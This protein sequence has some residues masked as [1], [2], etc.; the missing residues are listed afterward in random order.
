MAA[1][2]K[3]LSDAMGK[4]PHESFADPAYFHDKVLSVMEKIRAAVNDA[5]TLTPDRYWPYPAYS[6]LLFSV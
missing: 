2:V 4:A 6:R 5:E 3:E 1:L